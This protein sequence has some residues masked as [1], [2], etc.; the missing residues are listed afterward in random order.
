MAIGGNYENNYGGNSNSYQNNGSQNSNKAYEATYYSR[1]RLK[2][3]NDMINVSYRSGLMIL[4]LG[5]VG[6]EGFKFNSAIQIFLSPTKAHLLVDQINAFLKYRAG[7]D[8]DPAR[9]FGVNTGMGEKVSFIAFSTD[10]D[11]IIYI[12]IGKFDGQGTITE[13]YRFALNHEYNYALEWE[14]VIANKLYRVFDEDVEITMLKNAIEDFSR[15]S[16]GAVGYAVADMA[17]WDAHRM[18]K[19][20]DQI[21]DKLGI[22]RQNYSNSNYNNRGSNNFLDN[23]SSSS[24][25]TTSLEEMEDL[26]E[27]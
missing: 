23:A 8:I 15:T 20:I 17:R 25:R 4:D 3:K 21:F 11:K 18:N 26:L 6:S 10:A 1:L 14:D 5:S 19:R 22:E 27:G 7:D 9:G 13:S 24:S 16:N 2:N 12:T